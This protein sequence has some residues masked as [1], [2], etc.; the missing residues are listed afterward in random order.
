MQ[1]KILGQT[2]RGTKKGC[3]NASTKYFNNFCDTLFAIVVILIQ[4]NNDLKQSNCLIRQKY[5]F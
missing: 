5:F 2:F 3:D 1:N 4:P